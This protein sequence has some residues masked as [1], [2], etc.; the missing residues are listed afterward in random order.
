LSYLP[1]ARMTMKAIQ[2]AGTDDADKVAAV[3]RAMPVEDP[4]IRNGYWTGKKYFGI[5]QTLF[6][7]FGVGIIQGRQEPRRRTPGSQAGMIGS[8]RPARR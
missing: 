2:T 7:P 5:A 3:L 4:N 8:P 6:F 1:G